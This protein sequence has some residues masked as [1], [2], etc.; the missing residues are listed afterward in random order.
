MKYK[1]PHNKNKPHNISDNER[2]DKEE[3]NT[4][5]HIEEYDEEYEEASDGKEAYNNIS[6]NDKDIIFHNVISEKKQLDDEKR[7]ETPQESVQT[8]ALFD[9]I[10]SDN[11]VIAALGGA[12]LLFIGSY[13]SFWGVKGDV[14]KL[15]QGNLF[16]G[17]MA[18]GIFGKLCVL[19]AAVA[20]V[21]VCIRVYKAAWYVLL[22]SAISYIIQVLLIM[23]NG[24]NVLGNSMEISLYPG[25]GSIVC[26]AGIVIM[27]IFIKKLSEKQ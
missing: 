7:K 10:M 3:V 11:R 25:F 8:S 14:G 27:L 23:V 17:Y 21:L 20:A 1:K 6:D 19:A 26:L 13:L 9:S 18:G 15:S 16:T 2:M 4:D 5:I 12:I 24:K 22:I